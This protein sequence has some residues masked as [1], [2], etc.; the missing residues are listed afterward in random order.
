[1]VAE[2]ALNLL[3]SEEDLQPGRVVE[4]MSMDAVRDATIKSGFC[5]SMPYPPFYVRQSNPKRF[6]VECPSTMTKKVKKIKMGDGEGEGHVAGKTNKEVA[7]KTN[8]EV[9]GQTNNEEVASQTNEEVA[10]QTNEE[11]ADQKAD[12]KV[13]G[14]MNEEM[15]KEVAGKM[16]EEVAGQTN[17]SDNFAAVMNKCTFVISA[18]MQKRKNDQQVVII[19]LDLNHSCGCMLLRPGAKMSVGTSF[20]AAQSPRGGGLLKDDV[21]NAAPVNLKAAHVRRCHGAHAN[22]MTA[23]RAK[24]RVEEAQMSDEVRSF[25]LVQPYFS[26]LQMKMPGTVALMTRDVECRLLRTFIMLKPMV[27]AFQSCLPVLSLDACHMTNSFK[28]VL[29]MSATMILDGERQTQLLLGARHL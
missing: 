20:V 17:A 2:G 29:T 1:M 10:G 21:P 14:Q 23:H 11:V 8:E 22:Y 9:A 26:K 25:Q 19:K 7:G 16:N 13:A 3:L 4:F 28:G 27:T 5:W 18:R 24:K 15:N 6:V 12:Q